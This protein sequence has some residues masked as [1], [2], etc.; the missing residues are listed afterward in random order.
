MTQKINRLYLYSTISLMFII[1]IISI[2]LEIVI[3]QSHSNIWQLIGKWFVFWA[4][5]IRLFIAGLRQSINPEFIASEIFQFKSNESFAVIR[6]L[7]FAN[8][9]LGLIGIISLFIPQWRL[10]SAFSG[11]LYLGIAGIQHIIKK[12]ISFNE[13]IAMISDLLIFI[14]IIYYIINELYLNRNYLFQ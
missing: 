3:I 13:K 7:G 14:I 8:I 1:P 10:V 4:I 6:E 5:G 2:A 12:P 11:V 9:S